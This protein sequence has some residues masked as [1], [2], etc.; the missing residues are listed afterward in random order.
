[1]VLGQNWYD[2]SLAHKDI[3]VF[4][5]CWYFLALSVINGQ[6]WYHYSLAHNNLLYIMKCTSWFLINFNQGGFDI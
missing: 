2:Y 6:N 1:M 3:Q 5:P 4:S